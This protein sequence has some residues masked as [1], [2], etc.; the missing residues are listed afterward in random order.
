LLGKKSRLF[1]ICIGSLISSVICTILLA[2][3]LLFGI[4]VGFGQVYV[5]I[6][7]S[8]MIAGILSIITTLLSALKLYSQHKKTFGIG[9]FIGIILIILTFIFIAFPTSFFILLITYE[10]IPH[11]PDINAEITDVQYISVSNGTKNKWAISINF[12]NN[13]TDDYFAHNPCLITN[14]GKKYTNYYPSY[15]IEENTTSI[16]IFEY[17]IDSELEPE[18][19][20]FNYNHGHYFSSDIK[21]PI[22][23]EIYQVIG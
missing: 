11:Y 7:L 9:I 19:L 17:T 21:L 13:E 6:V 4:Y 18:F 20:E 8:I 15:L 3:Q 14:T 12:V 16:V 10:E 22:W 2:L 5:I 23:Y 1:K